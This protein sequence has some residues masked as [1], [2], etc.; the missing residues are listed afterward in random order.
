MLFLKDI[1]DVM[2][3]LSVIIPFIHFLL[4]RVGGWSLSRQTQ[5]TLHL[6]HLLQLILGGHRVV[7]C[8]DL[9]DRGN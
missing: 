3:M 8:R 1:S 4:I 6:T 7:Y 2:N 5:T 9:A